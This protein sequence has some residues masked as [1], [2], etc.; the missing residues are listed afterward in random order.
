MHLLP[1]LLQIRY[2]G[3]PRV[4]LERQAS[5]YSASLQHEHQPDSM[6]KDGVLQF[7]SMHAHLPRLARCDSG[8]KLSDWAPGDA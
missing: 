3:P 1:G 8:W 2:K 4:S 6:L 7:A 5:S